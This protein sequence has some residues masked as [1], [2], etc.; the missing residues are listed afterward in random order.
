MSPSAPVPKSHQ[1]RKL[2]GWYT[3]R[4]P[5]FWGGSSGMGLPSGQASLNGRIGA[6]PIHRFQSSVPGTGSSPSGRF[7]MPCGQTGR[8]DHTWIS[9]TAP[10]APAAINSV[11]RQPSSSVLARVVTC[12]ATPACR[13]AAVTARH[14]STVRVSGLT[15]QTCFLARRAAR[16]MIACVWSGVPQYT[17]STLSPSAASN[18]RKSR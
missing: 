16:V 5:Q 8:L 15:Q 7:G 6:G 13:A 18:S 3:L 10:I 14:S 1:P 11:V 2:N 17:A 9:R 12:V 4:A